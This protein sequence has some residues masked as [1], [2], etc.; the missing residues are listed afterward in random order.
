MI[1]SVLAL[2]FRNQRI[3]EPRG[4]APGAVVRWF[5]AMQAQDFGAA[6][7]AIGL[8]IR[9][10]STA[11]AVEEAFNQGKILRTH[12]MRP[13]WHFVLPQ[14]I[15]WMLDL[16]GPRVHSAIT[17][18]NQKI[19]LDAAVLTRATRIIGR[20]LREKAFLARDELGDQLGV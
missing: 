17:P 10:G 18:Y 8:R 15:R 5:G 19:G 2:R 12:L 4:A 6:M 1:P 3:A 7:W 9:G 11:A 20:S 13:T 14:D 16:T